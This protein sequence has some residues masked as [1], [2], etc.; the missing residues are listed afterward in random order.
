MVSFVCLCL[1]G[2]KLSDPHFG[3]PWNRFINGRICNVTCFC[4][5]HNLPLPFCYNHQYTSILRGSGFEHGPEHR[6]FWLRGSPPPEKSVATACFH[7]RYHLLFVCHFVIP[8]KSVDPLLKFTLK[9]VV[10]F[11]VGCWIYKSFVYSLE[12]F[13]CVVLCVC[14]H[15]YKVM[16]AQLL[17]AMNNITLHT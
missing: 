16:L 8:Q 1:R 6:L 13:S 9:C 17:C 10:N 12:S 15:R 7:S 2:K 11:S 5:A 4:A 14:V 3:H